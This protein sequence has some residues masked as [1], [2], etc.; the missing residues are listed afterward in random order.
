MFCVCV[1]GNILITTCTAGGKVGRGELVLRPRDDFWDPSPPR[2]AALSPG[3]T[4]CPSRD[5]VSRRRLHASVCDSAHLTGLYYSV[6][7]R[8]VTYLSYGSK[9]H[10]GNFQTWPLQRHSKCK[11]NWRLNF[12]KHL[13]LVVHLERH[14]QVSRQNV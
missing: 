14:C 4:H 5:T 6:V 10:V 2:R 8:A 3:A 13:G 1:H 12:W 7:Q 11:N 9:G